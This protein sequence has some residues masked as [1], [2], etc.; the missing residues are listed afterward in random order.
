MVEIAQT[1]T[2][3]GGGEKPASGSGFE[4]AEF[5]RRGLLIRIALIALVLRLGALAVTSLFPVK[6]RYFEPAWI[7]A[8][9]VRGEGFSSP[10]GS[11]SGPT[12]WLSPVYP[13]LL[14]GIFRIFGIASQSS[15]IAALAVNCAFSA[16]TCIPIFLIA[17]WSFGRR[18]AKWSAWLWA[19]L[20]YAMYW[21]VRWV[22]DTTLST[23]LLAVLFLFTLQLSRRS[24]LWRWLAYGLL[25]GVAGLTNAAMLGFLP[26]AALWIAWQCQR[27]NQPFLLRGTSAA[28]LCLAILT[29]WTVRNYYVFHK[30]IPLRGD[31]GVELHVGN[32]PTA[33]GP[34]Q[35]WLHPF[36]DPLE[37]R[38]YQQMGEAAY[39][40]EKKDEALRFIGEHPAQF[41]YLTLAHFIYYWYGLPYESSTILRN[42]AFFATSVLGVGG[43]LVALRRHRPGA[44]LYLLL[45]L[46]Y[47]SIYYVTFPHA[48]YR[49]PIEPQILILSVYLILEGT[50]T[51]PAQPDLS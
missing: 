34:G 18:I 6:S 24:E 17:D 20:P 5:D 36:H 33:M 14:A 50:K 16:L 49:H 31:F 1:E 12:A 8:S 3:A 37:L 9:I 10:F 29:P 39:V 44:V 13:W 23:L 38:R 15:G 30:F 21:G 2:M 28:V 43:M 42:A 25:W 46:S 11:P 19:L 45:F 51:K 22:W 27:E 35:A 4:N 32:S 48:R 47:P 26:F 41:A 7:A 40:A